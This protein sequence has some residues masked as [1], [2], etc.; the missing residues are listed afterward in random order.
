MELTEEQ[1]D[2]IDWLGVGRRLFHLSVGSRCRCTWRF[3][4]YGCLTDLHENLHAS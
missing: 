3:R 2:Y 1:W 4:G